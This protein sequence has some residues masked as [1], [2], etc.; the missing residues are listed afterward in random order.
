M[1][2]LLQTGP[3]E[4][5][6]NVEVERGCTLAELASAW[7]EKLP[8]PILAARVDNEIADLN[9]KID[10][11]CRV[12]LLDLRNPSANL[13]YQN[14][15]SLIYLKAVQDVLGEGS[16]EIQNSINKGLYTMIRRKNPVTQAE[17]DGIDQRMREIVEADLPIVKTE[18]GYQ[19][20]DFQAFFCGLMVPSTRYIQLFELRKYRRGVLLRFSHP[21]NPN[22]IPEYLDEVKMYEAFGEA[23]NWGKLM[24]VSYAEDLNAKVRSGE[25]RELIQLSEAL[26]EKKVAELA[27]LIKREKKRIILIAGPSSSGKTTFAN[28]LRIQLKVNGL[29]PIYMGTDDYFVEREDTPLDENGE[30]NFEDL[31]AIDIEL[32]N[33][34]M[35][36]LLAGEEVDLPRFDFMD[37]H[38]KFGHRKLKITANQP[39]I[40][41]G[42]HAL[43]E[44]LTALIPDCE[45]FKIYISPLTQLNIDEYNRI[46]TTDSRMLRRMVRDYNF[47][48][49]SAKSTINAWP[50]VRAGEDKNIF[51]FS[52]EADALFNS[53][54]L[55][56]ISVLKKYAEPL[57]QEIGKE[58]PEYSEAQ[59]MLRLLSFFEVIEDDSMIANNSIL[60][61][62]IGGSVLV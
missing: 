44:E 20:E 54:H 8:Y 37:G 33:A 1:K 27:D 48:G 47:R 36:A 18:A 28:R 35:N 59:R 23:T 58:E 30:P 11:P 24:E 45:K 6:Q 5:V 42:I 55:Y 38:K 10:G 15:L 49:H 4:E 53:V 60:R 26:H 51:P 34:N 19:L 62:F 56:E 57:L 52:N 61:E 14:S 43:N 13:T 40:I 12:E 2:I 9:W 25:Y 22:Q 16:V 50:K 17:V 41:E 7:Q 46:P 32:F 3:R 29:K 31:E 21:K 39:M